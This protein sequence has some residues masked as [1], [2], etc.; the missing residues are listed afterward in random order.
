MLKTAHLSGVTRLIMGLVVAALLASGQALAQG[1]VDADGFREIRVAPGYA[2]ADDFIDV[3]T[4]FLKGHPESLEGNAGMD[5]SIEKED[6]GYNVEIVLTGYLDDSLAGEHY[7][8]H[9]IQTSNGQWEL[10]SMWVKPIC[11]RGE[12][13][14]G[15][16]TTAAAPPAVFLTP[17]ASPIA[18]GMCVN[19]KAD[20][21]LNVRAGPGTRHQIVGSL[22]PGDCT[23]ELSNICEGN[24]C[25]IRTR[26]I[27][28]WVNTRYLASDN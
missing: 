11:G 15:V 8:G 19:V 24:W 13:V 7:K 12:N 3:L 2:I 26:Q 4:P 16:C 17:G 5:L 14:N 22:A 20:D 6:A 28:G 1:A 21:M 23:V 10:L 9:V 25:Q 27:S 18:T